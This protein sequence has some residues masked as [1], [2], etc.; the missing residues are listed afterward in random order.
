MKNIIQFHI[1]KSDKYYV[2]QGIDFPVVTQAKTLDE[3]AKNIKEAV[4]LHLEGQDLSKLDLAPNPS[5][6]LNMELGNA[7]YA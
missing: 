3:L 1:H 4:E 5:I 6:M 7:V 2:A